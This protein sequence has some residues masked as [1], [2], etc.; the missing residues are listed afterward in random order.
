MKEII[1]RY[2]SIE[3]RFFTDRIDDSASDEAARRG[4]IASNCEL[5]RNN[6]YCLAR[7]EGVITDGNYFRSDGTVVLPVTGDEDCAMLASN[8]KE[9]TSL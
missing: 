6:R 5:Q 3:L 9:A 7:E 1:N 8:E 2:T 4:K